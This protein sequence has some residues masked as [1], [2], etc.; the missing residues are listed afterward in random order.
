MKKVYTKAMLGGTLL[1]AAMMG[2]ATTAS[3]Q[4][5]TKVAV[6]ET[7][8][9]PMMGGTAITTKTVSFYDSQ[10]NLLRQATYEKDGALQKYHTYQYNDGGQL[11]LSFS[12][13]WNMQSNGIY[14][15]N[16]ATDSTSYEYNAD[17][18]LVKKTEPYNTYTYEYDTD[19]HLVKQQTLYY[20]SYTDETTVQNTTTYSAFDANGNATKVSYES[21]YSDENYE[22][23]LTYNAAGKLVEEADSAK[24]SDGILQLKKRKTYVYDENGTLLSTT[25]HIRQS[26]YDYDTWEITGYEV[27]PSDSIVYSPDGEGRV[28]EQDYYYDSYNKDWSASAT[29]LVTE[30]REF[31]GATAAEISVRVV[32]DAINTNS[33]SLTSTPDKSSVYDLYRDGVKIY[34]FEVG[35]DDMGTYKDAGVYNGDHEYFV[36]TVK[37][38]DTETGM[39]ISAIATVTD[40][41]DLPAPT[42]VRGV[43]QNTS[44]TTSDGYSTTTMTIAWDAPAYT[45]DMKFQGYNIMEAGEWGDSFYNSETPKQQETTYTFDMYGYY[46]QKENIYIQAVYECGVANSDTVTI[47]MAELPEATAIQSVRGDIATI[48]YKAGVISLSDAANIRVFDTTGKLVAEGKNATSLSLEAATR[49]VYVVTIERDGHTEALK[50]RR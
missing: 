36:Q 43:C 8:G 29:Y 32:A 27:V 14:A 5:A 28:K 10:N 31:D 23:T 41:V 19:G 49:G 12:R 17:G 39:N 15:F 42:N 38:G 7:H 9:D 18:K 13:Y 37:T 21:Q 20:N 34:R 48:S 30:T 50:V 44:A 25:T 2:F 47:A 33:I 26:V 1:A 3:A 4:K 11:V 16:A 24:D 45:D 40:K 46:T 22:G 6:E 35:S